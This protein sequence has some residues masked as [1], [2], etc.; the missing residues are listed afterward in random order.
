MPGLHITNQ[1]E[2]LDMQQ[3]RKS[4][5]Q[6]ASFAKAEAGISRRSGRRIE[7]FCPISVGA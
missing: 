1:Q 7:C 5:N 6:V 4:L 3:R 2:D